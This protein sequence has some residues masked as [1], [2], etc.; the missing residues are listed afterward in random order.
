M[1]NDRL[2]IRRLDAGYATAAHFVCVFR[3]ETGMTPALWRRRH[4]SPNDSLP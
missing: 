1:N 2:Q 3:R 4:N